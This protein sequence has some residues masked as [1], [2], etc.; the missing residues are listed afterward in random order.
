MAVNVS[1]YVSLRVSLVLIHY[2]LQV[3]KRLNNI[4]SRQTELSRLQLDGALLNNSR[5]FAFG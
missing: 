1:E 2:T 5:F 4:W 3:P